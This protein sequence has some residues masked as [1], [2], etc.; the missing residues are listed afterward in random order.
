MHIA[1]PRKP[2]SLQSQ[3]RKDACNERSPV[4]FTLLAS[5]CL[6]QLREGSW[7]LNLFIHVTCVTASEASCQ[8][9]ESAGSSF[10]VSPRESSFLHPPAFPVP[11]AGALQLGVTP[12]VLDVTPSA[13]VCDTL[14]VPLSL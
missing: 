8:G 6:T 11:G 5:L 9:A 13:A 12:P 2:P 3:G 1:G 4:H 14:S 7:E 10:A